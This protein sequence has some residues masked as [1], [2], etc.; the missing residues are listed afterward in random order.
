MH[1]CICAFLCTTWFN[2]FYSVYWR[3]AMWLCEKRSLR[4]SL[5]SWV[6]SLEPT[7]WRERQSHTICLLSSTHV[8]WHA[9]ANNSYMRVHMC[10]HAHAQTHMYSSINAKKLKISTY[11]QFFLCITP[12]REEHIRM[13]WPTPL[14]D[15]NMVGANWRV[16]PM[17]YCLEEVG[18]GCLKCS[19]WPEP[20]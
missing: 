4:P 1:M 20:S 2:L 14:A 18:S 9:Y 5:I 3:R 16:S 12:K 17:S 13:L 7:W 10:M 6:L 19:L 8:L 11:L 15:R